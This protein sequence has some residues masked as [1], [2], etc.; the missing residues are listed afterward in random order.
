MLFS[1]QE[2]AELRKAGQQPGLR[3]LGFKPR[4]WLQAWH[5]VGPLLFKPPKLTKTLKIYGKTRVLVL[6]LS[7]LET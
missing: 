3:L 4:A 2:V 5:N 6:N 1:V 7:I